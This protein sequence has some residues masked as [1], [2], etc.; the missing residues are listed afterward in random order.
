MY[1]YVLCREQAASYVSSPSTWDTR[2]GL[3]RSWKGAPTE[4]PSASSSGSSGQSSSEK[5][6]SSAKGNY[7]KSTNPNFIQNG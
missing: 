3:K 1:K 6:T 2:R 5:I 4:G 7:L